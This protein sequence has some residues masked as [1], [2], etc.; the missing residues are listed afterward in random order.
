MLEPAKEYSPSFK[1]IHWLIALLVILMLS[2]GFFLE[3]LPEQYIGSAFMV[4]KSIG[5]TILFL[6]IFRLVWV[7]HKG[8][9]P[10]PESVP[11]W[12]KIFSRLVQ[13]SFYLFLILMPLSGWI[14]SVAGE[15]IPAYFGLFS[16]PLPWIKPDKQLAHFMEEV[17]GIIAWVLIGLIVLHIV[18]A[19]KHHFYDKDNVLLTMLPRR[20]KAKATVE[21]IKNS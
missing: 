13:Y 7:S 17:H 9:L 6:M 11:L 16:M 14:M 21:M 19:L 12:E 2:A 20:K 3:D 5:I 4:H 15:R 10:L 18:G 1:F 8:K